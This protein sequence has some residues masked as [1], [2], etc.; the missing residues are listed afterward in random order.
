LAFVQLRIGEM[1]ANA[2]DLAGARSALRRAQG[3]TKLIS[4]AQSRSSRAAQIVEA[5]ANAGDIAGAQDTSKLIS[6]AR[7]K[8]RAAIG[9][10]KGQA[11]AGD[12]A[13]AQKTVESLRD[14]TAI[15]QANSAISDEQAKRASPSQVPASGSTP[16][17]NSPPAQPAIS[18]SDWTRELDALNTPLFLDLSGSVM[19]P[20]ATYKVI[21]PGASSEP[22]ETETKKTFRALMAISRAVIFANN[23]VDEMLQR[24]FAQ[25]AKP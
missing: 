23:T 13:G 14:P 15:L 16:S 4:S 10:V 7:E 22:T 12:F 17:S 3:Y 21:A 9:I 25:A 18:A 11:K 6:D 8:N 1:L 2:D 19:A 24:Q 20:L 5:Q